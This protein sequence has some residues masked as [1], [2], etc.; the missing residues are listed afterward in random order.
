VGSAHGSLRPVKQTIAGLMGI[1]MLGGLALPAA[2]EPPKPVPPWKQ[3]AAITKPNAKYTLGHAPKKLLRSLALSQPTRV[4]VDDAGG[5]VVLIYKIRADDYCD[6]C[7]DST[8]TDALTIGAATT[9]GAQRAMFL[10]PRVQTSTVTM[11]AVFVDAFGKS[12][13]EDILTSTMTRA[14][15]DARVDWNGLAGRVE[16]DNKIIYCISDSRFVRPS[17]FAA[18]EDP[19]CLADPSLAP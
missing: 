12:T 11:R 9:Y 16:T 19:G 7:S 4:L 17:I 10:N 8:E 13:A 6:L 15:V 1:F 18:L 2:A 14:T 3:G 5:A